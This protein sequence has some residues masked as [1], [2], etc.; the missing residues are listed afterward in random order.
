MQGSIHLSPGEAE[1]SSRM[2]CRALDCPVD[3]NDLDF[4]NFRKGR[5]CGIKFEDRDGSGNPGAQSGIPNWQIELTDSLGVRTR[6]T[7]GAEGNYCFGDLGPGTYGVAEIHQSGW[8][9]TV[10]SPPG[11]YTREV[12]SGDDLQDLNFGNRLEGGFVPVRLCGV[13]FEDLNGDGVRNTNE[14]GLP[15]WSISLQTADGGMLQSALSA[16]DGSYCFGS[17]GFGSYVIRE[18]ILPGW[19]QT[20]PAS[21]RLEVTNVSGV[22][23]DNLHLGNYRLGV[24]GGVKFNDANRNGRRDTGEQGLPGWTI[25]LDRNHDG[26]LNHPRTGGVCD[27]D[28][29]E[30]CGVTDAQGKYSFTDLPAGE[31]LVREVGQPGWSPT[32][33]LPGAIRL[34]RSGFVRSDVD[35]GN[36]PA[37]V[38]KTLYFPFYQGSDRFFTSFAVSNYSDEPAALRFTTYGPDG[39]LQDFPNNP[40]IVQLPAKHQLARLGHE[41]FGCSWQTPQN[42]WVQLESDNDAVG[43]FFQFGDLALNGLDGSTAVTRSVPRLYLQRVYEFPPELTT[44]ASLANPGAEEVEVLLR[45]TEMT[46]G[47]SGVTPVTVE[48]S[49]VIPPKGLLYGSI[50]ELFG[51]LPDLY[52]QVEVEV[53]RGAGVVGFELIDQQSPRTL[54]GLGAA[55]EF[56]KLEAYSAQLASGPD[57]FTT[58]KLF[59]QQDDLSWVYLEV[60]GD[61]A[62]DLGGG[63][64]YL[65]PGEQFEAELGWLFEVEPTRYFIGSLWLALEEPGVF[66]DVLFGDMDGRYAAA[67]PLQTSPFLEAVFS[68]VANGLGFFTGLALFNPGMAAAQVEIEVFSPAGAPKG[69]SQVT[70]EPRAR[71]SNT[72]Q[73]LV[74]ATSGLVGGYIMVRSTQPLVGQQLFGL[75]SLNLLSAVPPTVIRE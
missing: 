48:V 5:I 65:H 75:N 17:V 22:D 36:A 27:R 40:A 20:L 28:S 3:R 60:R 10:P 45:L 42:G 58:L 62:Q 68:H 38:A 9:Q 44:Y 55:V 21:G 54:V 11:T 26:V 64:I 12:R 18:T 33:P 47:V 19:V 16:G 15:G 8:A 13:K 52:G 50:T 61:Q 7:T 23:R 32:S 63:Y 30:P 66:G 4:G 69:S 29:L 73:E 34:N 59:N 35:F 39:E 70:I 49:R 1:L 41:L 53:K 57:I 67:L 43:S 46:D 14:P 25:F 37:S 51:A 71:L 56:N 74:P 72:L 24:I 6:A 2:R 31:Y